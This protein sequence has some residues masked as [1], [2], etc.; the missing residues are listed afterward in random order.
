VVKIRVPKEKN[1]LCVTF[2]TDEA[3]EVR[4]SSEW[5]RVN[6]M[7]SDQRL[8]GPDGGAIQPVFGKANVRI[9][10]VKPVGNYAVGIT[11]SDK[12]ETGIYTWTHLH[13]LHSNRAALM[14]EYV[15]SLRKH[16]LSRFPRTAK[17]RKTVV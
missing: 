8:P 11:F 13:E 15:R 10:D 14:R 5:L 2:S 4:L 1:A 3:A 7:A 6:S 12:H 9:D 17:P 16:G